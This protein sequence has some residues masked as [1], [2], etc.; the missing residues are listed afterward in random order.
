MISAR[1]FGIELA[2][3]MDKNNPNDF[4]VC[5]SVKT[6]GS[7]AEMVFRAGDGDYLEIGT[8]KGASAIIAASTKIEYRLS[9]MIY[10][11]DHFCGYHNEYIGTQEA[12]DNFKKYNVL[13]RINIIVAP[14]RPLPFM[15]Q[16][17]FES[18]FID[19]D[20]WEDNPYLDF[21]EIEG[22]VNKY[23][24]IDDYNHDARHTVME[25]VDRI[26]KDFPIW[27]ISDVMEGHHILLERIA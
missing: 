9:G 13:D 2:T 8:W 27:G 4:V 26:L 22:Q 23:I 7:L 11:V 10:C 1:E 5:K 6:Y 19:G 15:K 20:H 3:H 14:A 16:I 25:N 18:A 21:K 17:R 12:M 24:L